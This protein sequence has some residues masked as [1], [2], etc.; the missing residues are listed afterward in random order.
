[1]RNNCTQKGGGRRKVDVHSLKEMGACTNICIFFVQS[2]V[3]VFCCFFGGG[4][5]EFLRISRYL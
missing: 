4:R 2:P 5:G 3:V 1:M